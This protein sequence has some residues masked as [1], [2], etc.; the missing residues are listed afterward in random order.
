MTARKWANCQSAG[1]VGHYAN[2]GG[3]PS[4]RESTSLRIG[5]KVV[6]GQT[7]NKSCNLAINSA[8]NMPKNLVNWIVLCPQPR[9]ISIVALKIDVTIFERN[10]DIS[11]K[12][13]HPLKVP[14]PRYGVLAIQLN[15]NS[16]ENI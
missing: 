13:F 4:G 8:Y 9:Q 15:S 3:Q 1:V 2:A 14:N 16:F 6:D 11:R 7:L 12:L 10:P 5:A